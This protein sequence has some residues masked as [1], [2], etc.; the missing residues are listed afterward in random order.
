M[1]KL[2]LFLFIVVFIW[3]NMASKVE[4]LSYNLIS[5]FNKIEVRSYNSMVV[6]KVK[7]DKKRKIALKQGFKILSDYI[8]SNNINMTAPV[9]QTFDD[10]WWIYFIMPKSY[11]LENLPKPLNPNIVLA[12]FSFNKACVIKFSGIAND[13]KIK[14]K[15]LQLEKFMRNKYINVAKTYYAFFDPPWVL[16]L[17]RHNEIIA[18][19]E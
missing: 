8:F 5:S 9:L 14:L 11:T 4:R 18:M 13:N 15:S 7:I 6:A 16:P 3:V 1:K 10:G 12:N 17:F 2:W 19:I